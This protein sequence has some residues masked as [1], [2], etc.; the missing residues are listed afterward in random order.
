MAVSGDAISLG[1]VLASILAGFAFSAAA[2]FVAKQ[3]DHP[4]RLGPV[5]LYAVSGIVCLGSVWVGVLYFSNSGQED[6]QGLLGHFF[7][8]MLAFGTYFFILGF[9]ANAFFQEE[10]NGLGLFKH[11]VIV[12]TVAVSVVVVGLMLA[13]FR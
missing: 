3:E 2:Q 7:F 8:A 13:T 12:F 4:A 1:A 10:R 6:D 11:F 5:A 9:F